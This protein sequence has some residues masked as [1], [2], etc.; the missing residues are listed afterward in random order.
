MVLSAG[1]SLEDVQAAAGHADP[2]T[3]PNPATIVTVV[4]VNV[5]SV[6]PGGAGNGIGSPSSNTPEASVSRL[7]FLAVR[8]ALANNGVLPSSSKGRMALQANLSPGAST[9]LAVDVTG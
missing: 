2:S 3:A 8:N 4:S 5:A 9:E 1:A 6:N 7:P